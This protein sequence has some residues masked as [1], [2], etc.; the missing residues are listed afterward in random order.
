MPKD[1]LLLIPQLWRRSRPRYIF[2]TLQYHIC[3]KHA[4]LS[5]PTKPVVQ[6]IRAGCPTRKGRTR[7][8]WSLR[9]RHSD[10]TSASTTR[11]DGNGRLS[12]DNR[13]GPIDSLTRSGGDA[14]AD[15]RAVDDV[16]GG[17][18]DC[19]GDVTIGHRDCG[20][21]SVRSHDRLAVGYVG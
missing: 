9:D 2:R 8:A 21:N 15:N 7:T 3:I 11:S 6:V 12:G 4:P 14:N 16:R 1:Q 5:F 19:I 20:R 18:G 10:C 17:G 13:L